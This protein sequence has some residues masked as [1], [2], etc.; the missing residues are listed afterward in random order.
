MGMRGIKLIPHYQGYPEEGPNIEVACRW[1]HEHRQIILNHYWGPAAHLEQL[2]AKYPEACYIAGHMGYGYEALVKARENL[3]ICTCP[4]WH[5]PRACEKAVAA[6]GADR[7]LF[8]SDLQDLPIAWGLGPILFGHI[9]EADK[10]AMLG[11][12]LQRLLQR[13]SAVQSTDTRVKVYQSQCC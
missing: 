3:F 5:G 13:Y 9:S 11:G 2:M 6:Y 10:A 12:N 8:G 7:L 1:A 4:L